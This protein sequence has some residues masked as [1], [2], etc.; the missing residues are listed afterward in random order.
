MAIKKHVFLLRHSDDRA[1]SKNS[2]S[3]EYFF[4]HTTA[5]KKHLPWGVVQVRSGEERNIPTGAEGT[6]QQIRGS[7]KSSTFQPTRWSRRLREAA[8]KDARTACQNLPLQSEALGTLLVTAACWEF[9]VCFDSS[10]RSRGFSSAYSPSRLVVIAE[11]IPT[12]QGPIRRSSP[13]VFLFMPL[14]FNGARR[15]TNMRRSSFYSPH[16]FFL[17]SVKSRFKLGPE[18]QEA[19]ERNANFNFVIFLFFLPLQKCLCFF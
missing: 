9:H 2:K 18:A 11:N 15:E 16:F 8:A 5:A 14:N 12:W 6:K 7:W 1:K 19:L 10:K 17:L 13:L 3:E 4:S